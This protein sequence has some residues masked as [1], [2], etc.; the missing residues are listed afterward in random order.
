MGI[1]LWIFRIM[2]FI[3]LES[4]VSRGM[5][6]PRDIIMVIPVRGVRIIM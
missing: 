4:I 6:I 5:T 1:E 3:G 2:Q